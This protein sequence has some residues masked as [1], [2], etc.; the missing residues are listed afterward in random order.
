MV[1]ERK[2]RNV[3][4][5]LSDLAKQIVRATLQRGLNSGVICERAYHG[6]A[7]QFRSEPT[8][9]SVLVATG[10]QHSNRVSRSSV[11]EGAGL[12]GVEGQ[13]GVLAGGVPAVRPQGGVADFMTRLKPTE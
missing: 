4:S 5:Y 2:G 7:A 8:P 10:A 11:Q 9:V 1:L 6:C 3:T 12:P 13:S